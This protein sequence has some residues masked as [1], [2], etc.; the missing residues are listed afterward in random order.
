MTVKVFISHSHLDRATAALLTKV[1]N[2]NAVE[3]FLT[4]NEVNAGDALPERLT[5]GIEWCDKILLLW[6]GNA[7]RSRWVQKEWNL[8]YELRKK[9]VP[10]ALDPK[11]LPRVLDELVHVEASDQERGHGGL[12]SAILGKGF[13]PTDPKQIV[14]GYWQV[15]MAIAGL[16]DVTYDLRLHADGQI[17][18]DGHMGSSGV[19]A[20]LMQTAG[21]GYMAGMKLRC[22]GRWSFDNR[23]R[24]LRL[25]LEA[26]GLGQTQRE[27][28]GMSMVDGRSSEAT[29]QDAMGRQW[30]M[31]RTA[32]Q[33]IRRA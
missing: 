15:K 23:A 20:N 21:M 1:L 14:P 26:S 6:S 18:G 13:I 22:G 11:P 28:I 7:A 10:Y 19:F 33:D 24:K 30:R 12:L 25:D 16:G 9:I 17:S 29:G 3:T 31:V 4:Q 27:A 8:A 5:R 2:E 32:G